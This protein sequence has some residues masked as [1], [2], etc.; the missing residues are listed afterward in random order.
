MTDPIST[1]SLNYL[2]PQRG[3]S[4][5]IEVV[6][7]SLVGLSRTVSIIKLIPQMLI[8]C[9]PWALFSIMAQ[10]GKDELAAALDLKGLQLDKKIE[11]YNVMCHRNTMAKCHGTTEEKTVYSCTVF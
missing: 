5:T 8:E 11:S 10:I 7:R 4:A 3:H 1:Y 6:L 9:Q 2:L